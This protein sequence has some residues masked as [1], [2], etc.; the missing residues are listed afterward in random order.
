MPKEF[1]KLQKGILKSLKK[2]FPKMSED[3]LKS[4]SFAIATDRFAKMGKKREEKS[5]IK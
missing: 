1:D 4:R 3:E 5:M 2:Q